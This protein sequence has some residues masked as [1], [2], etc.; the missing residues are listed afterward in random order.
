MRGKAAGFTLLE[1]VISMLIVSAIVLL[2]YSSYSTVVRTWERNQ[3]L[4][5]DFRLEALGDRLLVQDWKQMQAYGYTTGKGAF[6]FLFGSPTRLAYATRHGLGGRRSIDG[7][8]FFSLLM[9]EP[10]DEGVGVYCYKA[11]IPELEMIDL[12]SA[13][14]TS[15]ETGAAALE[16]RF[17]EKAILLK[18]ADEAEFSFD[19]GT[20]R[21]LADGTDENSTDELPF[22]EW[23]GAKLPARVRLSLWRNETAWVLE[24]GP[25]A[26]PGFG[27]STAAG[28][29]T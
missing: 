10:R 17:L 26:E 22:S 24:G 8:L 12:V 18:E 7:R 11:D 16:G 23:R 5:D 4:A 9:I 15:G 19:S 1:M 28:G 6:H 2:I 13:Y 3:E 14:L 21:Q 20:H 25:Q 29:A 27:N